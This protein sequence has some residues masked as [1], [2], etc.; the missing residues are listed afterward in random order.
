MNILLLITVIV[1]AIASFIAAL[2]TLDYNRLNA[3]YEE[4]GKTLLNTA[5]DLGNE[6]IHNDKLSETIAELRSDK[7]KLEGQLTH[8]AKTCDDIQ[9]ESM[10]KIKS[11]ETELAKHKRV[12]DKRGVFVRKDGTFTPKPKKV[13]PTVGDEVVEPVK[14]VKKHTLKHFMTVKN[15]SEAEAKAIFKAAKN[16]GI[17]STVSDGAVSPAFPHIWYCEG[18]D[19]Y[20]GVTDYEGYSDSVIQ[21][22]ATEFLLRIK[23]EIA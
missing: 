3:M 20:E 1:A 13:L 15:P 12:R 17:E 4:R 16:A 10:A 23:G 7:S 9:A 19:Y 6:L 5:K 22:S 21:I 14:E 8:L 18:E 2:K 11:L